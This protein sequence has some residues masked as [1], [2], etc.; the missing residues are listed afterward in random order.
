VLFIF[1]RKAA[2]AAAHSAFPAP[3]IV[4]GKLAKLGQ[5]MPRECERVFFR[6][7]GMVRQHQTSDAQLRI[8]VRRLASPRNDEKWLFDN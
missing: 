4:R 1:A 8:V 6:H 5:I 3:S 7:S 2:G